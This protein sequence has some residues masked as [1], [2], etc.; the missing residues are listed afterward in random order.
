MENF[1]FATIILFRTCNYN[2]SYCVVPEQEKRSKFGKIATEKGINKLLNFF[3]DKGVWNIYLGGGEPTIHPQFIKL[4]KKITNKH[5]LSFVTN[6]SMSF[7]K[8]NEFIKEINPEKVSYIQC[9]LQ[10]V[11]EEGENFQNFLKR[12][13]LYNENG[14]KAYVS[15]VGVPDRFDKIKKYYEI[16]TQNNIP[17]VVQVF[18]GDF[19]GKIYPESYSKENMDYI[20]KYNSS[21]IYKALFEINKRKTAGKLCSAGHTRILINAVDGNIRRCLFEPESIG[22]LYD[23][24]VNLQENYF[25]CKSPICTCVFEPNLD[26]E[27]LLWDDINHMFSGDFNYDKKIYEEYKEKSLPDKRYYEMLKELE[28][29]ENIKIKNKLEKLF[30]NAHEKNI[31]I[32]GT[33]KHSE[34]MLNK[35]K[36]FIGDIDFNVIFFNSSTDCWEKDFL[37]YKINKPADIDILNLDRIIISSYEFQEEIYEILKKYEKMGLNVIKIYENDEKIMFLER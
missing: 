13:K 32:Y 3:A 2:C 21:S 25:V 6:N 14:F 15:Y 24:K 9:S 30:F 28:E 36:E 35:Y 18:H 5:Y 33:G 27:H 34:I 19:N 26:V 22:N 8:L 4:C 11:D 31:G 7:E 10:E 16:F 17:F 37:G 23:N 12:M 29:K 20:D 1:K